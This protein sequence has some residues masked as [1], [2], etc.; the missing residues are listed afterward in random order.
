[1]SQPSEHLPRSDDAAA[2]VLGVLDEAE[3]AEFRSHADACAI[4]GAEVERLR[5]TAA[6]LPFAAPQLEAPRR[7][8]RRV[9]AAA[10]DAPP[11]PATAPRR[12]QRR[13]TRFEF[14]GA[15]GLAV[16]LAIGA[17]VLAPS[18]PSTSVIR[19]RVASAAAW[20]SAGRPAAW[21]KRSGDHAEL[22]V[23]RLPQAGPGKVYELWIERRGKAWPTDALFEPNNRGQADANVPGGVAGA[24]AVLVTA[25]PRGGTK[26]PTMA[27]LID[28][29]L[30]D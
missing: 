30:Q 27:P 7:L 29:S 1:M 14:A 12:A 3:A 5:A 13:R 11:A 18:N 26:V 23:E 17:L 22:V 28:A 25:E 8:R 10:R 16:G 20:H 19:A 15:G 2:Y 6:L 24:S 21:L 4:C 9:L